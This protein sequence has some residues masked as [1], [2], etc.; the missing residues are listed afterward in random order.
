ML[1]AYKMGD[2]GK[3]KI[4][5]YFG[6]YSIPNMVNTMKESPKRMRER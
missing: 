1:E 5:S 3:E 6:R 2:A 4:L